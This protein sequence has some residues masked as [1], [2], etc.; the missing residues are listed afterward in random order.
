[1]VLED[2]SGRVQG[3]GALEGSP[4]PGRYR[5]F[6]IVPPEAFPTI[7]DSLY[8]RLEAAWR[9]IGAKSIWMREE[10]GDVELLDFMA[11]KGFVETHRGMH[12]HLMIVALEKRL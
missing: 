1:V 8:G 9:E 12:E 4:E 7:G 3:Y 10:A 6:L 2:D 11:G 5:L